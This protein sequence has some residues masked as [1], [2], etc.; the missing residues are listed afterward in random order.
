[1]L[2]IKGKLTSF[3]EYSIVSHGILFFDNLF[4]YYNL[5]ANSSELNRSIVLIL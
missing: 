2:N 3:S 1:M 5:K 4:P